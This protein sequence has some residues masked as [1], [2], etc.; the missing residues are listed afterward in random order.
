[1]H[2]HMRRYILFPLHY[3]LS[4]NKAWITNLQFLQLNWYIWYISNIS[5]LVLRPELLIFVCAVCFTC[6]QWVSVVFYFRCVLCCTN[7]GMSKLG[8]FFQITWN[9]SISQS[10]LIISIATFGNVISLINH[11]IQLL[12]Y[13]LSSIC[14]WWYQR[15][16]GF[17]CI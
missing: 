14:N 16:L 2:V 3:Y 17:C 10:F 12:V 15:E 8:F 1:M 4:L 13:C 7:S 6:L 11:S 9:C 5:N